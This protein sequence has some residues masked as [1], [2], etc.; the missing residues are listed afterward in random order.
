MFYLRQA[1][2]TLKAVSFGSI[3]KWQQCT[4]K[5]KTSGGKSPVSLW[6]SAR[7]RVTFRKVGRV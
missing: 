4:Q 1:V 2:V 5:V 6:V 7:F 3:S